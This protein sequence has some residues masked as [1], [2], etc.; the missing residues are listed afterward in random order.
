M[1]KS[2]L[3]LAVLLAASFATTA[4]AA[5]KRRAAAKPAPISSNE[6]SA[7]LVGGFVTA[8]VFPPAAVVTSPVAPAKRVRH[9]RV[10]KVKMKKKG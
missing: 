8:M 5:R 6:A 9:A 3:L 7:N 10:K 4:D 1:R 2:A